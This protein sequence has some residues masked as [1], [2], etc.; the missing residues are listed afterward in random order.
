MHDDL[1]DGLGW[2]LAQGIGEPDR[3]GFFGC[4]YSGYSALM[5]SHLH[6]RSVWHPEPDQLHHGGDPTLS[7][8]VVARVQ[9][10]ARPRH[11]SRQGVS[12]RPLAAQPSGARDQVHP[13]RPGHQ[14]LRVVSADSEQMVKALTQ[15]GVPVTYLAFADEGTALCGRRTASPSARSQNL[16]G[17]VQ[18]VGGDFAGASIRIATGREFVPGLP[19]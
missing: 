4:S 12:R 18:P 14:D 10:A 2:A 13:D 15:R 11:R 3:T 17:R 9:Q 16:G 7:D 5:A 19:A 6:R 1:I 8:A